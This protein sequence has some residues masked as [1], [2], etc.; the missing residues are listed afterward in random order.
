MI[1]AHEFVAEARQML[2]AARS[3]EIRR[4]TAASRAYYG[5]YH[6]FL[7]YAKARGYAFSK[8]D[9]K[10]MHEHLL[11]A[12]PDYLEDDDDLIQMF[13]DLETLKTLRRDCDYRLAENIP[14]E[15]VA[16]AVERAEHIVALMTEA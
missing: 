11:Q 4:R 15:S 10:G 5:C 13:K 2:Q 8:D 12:L 6:L 1:Q 14:Y 16:F 3:S 7:A 9:R